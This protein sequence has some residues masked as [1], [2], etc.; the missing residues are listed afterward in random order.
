MMWYQ[1]TI[2][3]DMACWGEDAGLQSFWIRTLVVSDPGVVVRSCSV[4]ITLKIIYINLYQCEVRM[5]VMNTS[6]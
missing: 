2:F 1:V 5:R 3:V 6:R 4:L